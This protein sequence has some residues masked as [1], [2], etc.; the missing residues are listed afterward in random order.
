MHR[1]KY[2]MIISEVLSVALKDELRDDL[3]GKKYSILMDEATD[4]SSEK[5]VFLCIK[6]F[7]EKHLC[8]EDQF[9]GL[10]SVIEITGEA[11]F[12]AMQTLLHEFKLN[13][14]DCVGFGTDGA[15]NMTGENNSVW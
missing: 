2:S 12:N 5:K 3:E 4:I 15:N 1:M 13:L 10:V 9:L 14:R 6:Y 8:V 11:L 7:S